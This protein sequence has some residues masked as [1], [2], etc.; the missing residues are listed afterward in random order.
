M[1]PKTIADA[2]PLHAVHADPDV[3]RHLGGHFA[4]RKRTSELVQKHIDHQRSYGFST[5]SLAERRSDE[6]IGDVGFL[7]HQGGV[8]IGWHVRRASWRL[9]YATEAARASLAYGF[10]A[11][12]ERVSA[13][14]ETANVGSVNVIAKLRMTFV[15]SGVEGVPPCPRAAHCTVGSGAAGHPGPDPDGARDSRHRAAL[16]TSSHEHRRAR[17]NRIAPRRCGGRFEFSAK[18]ETAGI[19]PASAV[20]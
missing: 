12:F 8:A 6:I 19:E 1:R 3:M 10:A 4:T 7:A 18:V 2:E 9:G 14:V 5:W 16:L 11:H 15:G 13:F 20:A 17:L